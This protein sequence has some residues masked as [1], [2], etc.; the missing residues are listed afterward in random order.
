LCYQVFIVFAGPEY[1]VEEPSK[2]DSSKKI[3]SVVQAVA[4]CP[5]KLQADRR[6]D[7]VEVIDSHTITGN[8]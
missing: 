3:L 7:C 8:N 5:A 1:C 2:I 6:K 4:S